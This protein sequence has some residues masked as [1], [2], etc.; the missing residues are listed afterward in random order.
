MMIIMIRMI[1]MIR[2]NYGPCGPSMGSGFAFISDTKV[3]R[4]GGEERCLL[5]H[6]LVEGDATSYYGTP[7][8]F[9]GNCNVGFRY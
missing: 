2:N 5:L 6:I 4:V 7:C 8:I 9:A 3:F 1:R